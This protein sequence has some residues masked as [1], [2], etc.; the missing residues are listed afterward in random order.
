MAAAK[1]HAQ[2]RAR[3]STYQP[4]QPSIFAIRE[5][6]DEEYQPKPAAVAP[7]PAPIAQLPTTKEYVMVRRPRPAM[8]KN[9][10]RVDSHIEL[11]EEDEEEDEE[12]KEDEDET[13]SSEEESSE[14]EAPAPVRRR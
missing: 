12:G 11:S 8:R 10:S 9:A 6:K 5:T 1:G 4:R 2:S 3:A 7:T 14:E 13:E